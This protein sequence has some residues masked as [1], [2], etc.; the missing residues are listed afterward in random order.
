MAKKSKAT[1]QYN[2]QLQRQQ[3]ILKRAQQKGIRLDLSATK[4]T[5]QKPTKKDI[6]KLRKENIYYSKN[7]KANTENKANLSLSA[8]QIQKAVKAR[9]KQTF[10]VDYTNEADKIERQRKRKEEEKKKKRKEQKSRRREQETQEKIDILRD[11]L[12]KKQ[13]EN[14]VQDI[15]PDI[16]PEP[17]PYRPE[18]PT[19]PHPPEVNESTSFYS[20]TIIRMYK[21]ELKNYPQHAEP[22]INAWL[23]SLIQK[24]G[25]DDVAQMIQ[26]ASASGIILTYEIAYD[27]YKIHAYIA[28][29][30]NYLP[31]MTPEWAS[32]VLDAFDEWADIR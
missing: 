22:L 4:Q 27:V 5:Q 15:E 8:N 32:D 3:K 2:K 25:M 16:E 21:Q 18:E 28:E 17:E 11:K 1:R 24:Y 26:E 23:D 12:Q 20:E 9:A 31:E 14:V 7:L 19:R 13:D 29:M 30:L 10:R 6:V